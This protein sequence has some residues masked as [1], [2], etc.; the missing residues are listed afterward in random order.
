[1]TTDSSGARAN[2]LG[3]SQLSFVGVGAMAE[4]MIA[5]LLRR[6]LVTPEQITGSHP[7]AARR[8]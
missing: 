3:A 7:R 5:G 8:E 4:A 6:E 2:P 1:M